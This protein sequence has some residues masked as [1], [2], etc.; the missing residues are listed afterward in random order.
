[1]DSIVLSSPITRVTGILKMDST[2]EVA[3]GLSVV[4]TNTVL[5]TDT[6]VLFGYVWSTAPYQA[7]YGGVSTAGWQF[8]YLNETS[9]IRNRITLDSAQYDFKLKTGTDSSGFI[10]NDDG[11]RVYNT[12]LTADRVTTPPASDSINRINTDGELYSIA[13]GLIRLAGHGDTTTLYYIPEATYGTTITLKGT[14]DTNHVIV[15]NGGNIALAG[16]LSFALKDNYR[17]GL[18]FVDGYWTE[19]FRSE[20]VPKELFTVG[21]DVADS[22]TAKGSINAWNDYFLLTGDTLLN[23][24]ARGRNCTFYGGTAATLIANSDHGATRLILSDS[25][26]LLT[27]INFPN[28]DL[29]QVVIPATLTALTNITINAN[30]LT[31][32]WIPP[33]LTALTTLDLSDNALSQ[34]AVDMILYNLDQSGV[35]ACTIALSGG[36]NAS[37][38]DGML[39]PNYVSLVAKGNTIFIN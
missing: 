34:Q 14:S 36:T 27:G 29:T 31:S 11:F 10:L 30:Q 12:P 17:M 15:S 24:E 7:Y 38:T 35:A 28:N 26:T 3:G 2:L 1:M 6:N 4:N 5:I 9:G 19:D 20:S 8:N 39:N 23:Y 16:G 32:I 37:P 22:V 21:Y 33:T 25:L 18:T 13:N